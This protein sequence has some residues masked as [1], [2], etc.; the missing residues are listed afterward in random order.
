MKTII[1]RPNKSAFALARTRLAGMIIA[2]SIL[3]IKHTNIIRKIGYRALK[4]S[5]Y[6][7]SFKK[8]TFRLIMPLKK[9]K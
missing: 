6:N 3:M 5:L 8:A 2:I 1:I 7:L 9:V 4:R